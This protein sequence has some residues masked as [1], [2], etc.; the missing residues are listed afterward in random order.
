[1]H[2][3]D[4]RVTRPGPSTRRARVR[5]RARRPAAPRPPRPRIAPERRL[6]R[7]RNPLVPHAFRSRLAVDGSPAAALRH[8]AGRGHAA[9]PGPPSGHDVTDA[10]T[11]E[12]PGQDPARAASARLSRHDLRHDPAAGLL[13]HR[14]RDRALGLP[15]RR[16]RATGACR[17]ERAAP[18][19]ARAR[20]RRSSGSP[21]TGSPTPTGCSST[22]TPRAPGLANQGWKDSGDSI[23]WRDGTVADAP[24]ALVE[25]QAYA[26]EALRGARASTGRSGLDGADAARGRGRPRS[27]PAL[28]DRFW[29]DTDA[30]RHLAIALDGDGPRG[31]RAGLQH[32]PRPRHVD[33]DPRRGPV[34]GG[35]RDRCRAARRLRR[36]HLRHRQRRLQPHRLPHRVDLDPRHRDHGNRPE[37]RGIRRRSGAR[38]RAPCSPPPRPSPTAGPSSTPGSRSPAPRRPIPPRAAPRRGRPPRPSRS[39]AWRCAPARR[40]DPHPAPDALRPSPYGAMRVEGLRFLGSASTSPSTPTAPSRCSPRPTTC[41]SSSTTL[42]S[43]ERSARPCRPPG[44]AIERAITSGHHDG[45]EPGRHTA[46]GVVL[47]TIDG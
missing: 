36:A 25:A 47:P 35:H 32:G 8:R 15:A 26:V 11:G 21:A 27:R 40:R 38:S 1:M 42:R 5:A 23:R 39:S 7:G 17:L 43:R 20:R 13:R 10:R 33:A 22:S 19:A 12:A 6:R 18:P 37:P 24:I 9:H 29:V 46:S 31:R 45:V 16:G 28:R 34:G 14:R 30:G 3:D 41:P 2:W 44:P 4:V